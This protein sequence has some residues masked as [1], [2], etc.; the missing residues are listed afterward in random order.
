MGGDTALPGRLGSL[1][2]I[3]SS[4]TG[5]ETESRPKMN[6][7]HFSLTKHFCTVER[8][9]L[10]KVLKVALREKQRMQTPLRLPAYLA[11]VKAGRVHLCRVAGNTVQSYM[12]GDAP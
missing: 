8:R 5:S 12:A 1:G 3:L 7:V 11:G 10:P 4:P 2:S 9:L 6:S